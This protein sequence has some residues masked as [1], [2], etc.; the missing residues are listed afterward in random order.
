[1]R[2]VCEIFNKLQRNE[3]SISLYIGET[4]DKRNDLPFRFYDFYKL[5][6]IFK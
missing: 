5:Y 4:R 2:T 1:M 6:K 3:Y